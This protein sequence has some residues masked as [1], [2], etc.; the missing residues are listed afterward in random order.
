MTDQTKNDKTIFL[1]GV[2][3]LEGLTDHSR[4]AAL[5][6]TGKVGFY[7]Q[8]HGILHAHGEGI[9][10][11]VS[12]AMQPYGPGEAEINLQ[13]FEAIDEWFEKVWGPVW[14]DFGLSPDRINSVINFEDQYWQK[15]FEATVDH[16]R[17]H[18]VETIAP[19]FSPNGE[20]MSLDTF[21]ENPAYA[22]IRDAATLGGAFTLDP[23]PLFFFQ[24]SPEYRRFSCEQVRWA[25]ENKL[26]SCVI[27]SPSGNDP[28]FLDHVQEFVEF[29]QNENAIPTEWVMEIYSED[30]NGLGSTRKPNTAIGSALWLAREA[31]TTPYKG[32]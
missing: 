18:G 30:T 7:M 10:K 31:P 29:F 5:F 19:I 14:N 27:I 2:V 26:R 32:Q 17:K 21:A 24:Q 4:T 12:E 6:N 20:N 16:F 23:P 15:N 25:N 11:K 1:G 9:L 13:Y 28:D 22:D 3:D 8:E